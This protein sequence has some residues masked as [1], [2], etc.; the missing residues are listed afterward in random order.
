MLIAVYLKTKNAL[1]AE[2]IR[3]GKCTLEGL[4]IIDKI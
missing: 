1:D 4:N 2:N 3:P